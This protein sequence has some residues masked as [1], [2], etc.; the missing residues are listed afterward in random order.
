LIGDL[1]DNQEIYLIKVQCLFLRRKKKHN[2]EFGSHSVGNL[3]T[4]RAINKRNKKTEV[5]GSEKKK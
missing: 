1:G 3:I 4:T 2:Q 5:Q